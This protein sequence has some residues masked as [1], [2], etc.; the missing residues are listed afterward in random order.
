MDTSIFIARIICI[1][2]LSFGLGMILSKDFYLAQL[3]KLIEN[4]GLLMLG[5]FIAIVCGVAMINYHSIWEFS[6]KVLITIIGWV[7]LIK[8]TL[9][10]V[11]PRISSLYGS[12]LTTQFISKIAAPVCLIL[13]GIMG[14]FGF[15][16]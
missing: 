2:Y 12:V 15:I 6:W 11:F 4:I 1:V 9:L 16:V 8:G 10:L 3:P 7:A 5:G 13:G 14:Y